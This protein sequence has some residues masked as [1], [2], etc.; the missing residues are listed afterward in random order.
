MKGK[1]ERK[2][3][4]DRVTLF[5]LKPLPFVASNYPQIRIL[6]FVSLLGSQFVCLFVREL[7]WLNSVLELQRVCSVGQPQSPLLLFCQGCAT[8]CVH[9]GMMSQQRSLE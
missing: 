2:K 4:A 1:M 7:I 6:I 8:G 9:S 5:Y 3:K